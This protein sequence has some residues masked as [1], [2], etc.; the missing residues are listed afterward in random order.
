[1][2]MLLKINVTFNLRNSLM[3]DAKCAI[4]VLPTK[5]GIRKL[6]IESM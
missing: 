1:M 6:L 2:M 5:F 3:I 4:T